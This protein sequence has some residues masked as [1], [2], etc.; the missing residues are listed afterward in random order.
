M[1]VKSP[2]ITQSDIDHALSLCGSPSWPQDESE[3]AE[4]CNLA[5]SVAEQRRAENLMRNRLDT[6][7]N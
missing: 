7:L 4:L 6:Q 5:I 3:L 1:S 2:Y